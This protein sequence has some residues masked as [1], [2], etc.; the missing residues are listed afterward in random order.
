MEE[1]GHKEFVIDTLFFLRAYEAANYRAF[2]SPHLVNSIIG[3]VAAPGTFVSNQ[4]RPSHRQIVA[5]ATLT[6]LGTDAPDQT[7]H[8]AQPTKSATWRREFDCRQGWGYANFGRDF[9]D[10]VA[11]TSNSFGAASAIGWLAACRNLKSRPDSDRGEN[12]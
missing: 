5:G 7:I 3:C 9:E 8:S 12:E 6:H 1:P 11:T 10:D 4:Q 2:L